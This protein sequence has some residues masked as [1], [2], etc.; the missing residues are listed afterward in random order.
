AGKHTVTLIANDSRGLSNSIDSVQKEIFITPKPN[1][2]L[3][4]LPSD[5]VVGASWNIGDVTTLPSVGFVANGTL[6]NLWPA[7][8]A[9]DQSIS[10]G[11]MPRNVVLSQESFAVHV[12]DAIKFVS[13]PEPQTLV[14]NPSNP[15]VVLTAPDVNRPETR[16]VKYEWRKGNALIGHGKVIS[17]PLNKGANTFTVKVFD[18]DIVGSTP[19]EISIAVNC[20]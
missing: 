8:A 13:S 10:I 14:W 7:T 18:E 6:A 19:V 12:W 16:K 1:L 15:S 9:G 3:F 5:F 4:S 2:K 11:W 17:A 20:E